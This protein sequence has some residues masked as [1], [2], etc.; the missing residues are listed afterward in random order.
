VSL[1]TGTLGMLGIAACGFDGIAGPATPDDGTDGGGGESGTRKDGSSDFPLDMPDALADGADSLDAGDGATTCTADLTIDPLNCG[2]CG[3]S[4]LGGLCAASKCTPTTLAIVGQP[5]E[6]TVDGTDVYWTDKGAGAIVPNVA[7]CPKAGGAQISV[8]VGPSNFDPASLVVASDR[9]VFTDSSRNNVYSCPLPGPGCTSGDTQSGESHPEGIAWNGTSVFWANRD[10]GNLRR[11]DKTITTTSFFAQ[12]EGALERVAATA[13]DVFWTVPNAIHGK[14]ITSST[15]VS[16]STAT[17]PRD[18]AMNAT[19]VYFAL[20][21]EIRRVTYAGLD[22][23][24]V[25]SSADIQRIAVDASGLYFT[26]RGAGT[27]RILRCPLAGCV[28]PHQFDVIATGESSPFGIA[29]DAT[30]VY[31]ANEVVAGTIRRVAK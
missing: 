21:S 15:N 6:L 3:H 18:I 28:P 17:A 5:H 31:W 24:V 1:V 2:R 12:N 10:S 11:G 4:C 7:R 25:A 23:V 9:V 13:T 20:A 14:G 8:A 19:H 30:H 29:L 27:G 16:V 26:D 22:N